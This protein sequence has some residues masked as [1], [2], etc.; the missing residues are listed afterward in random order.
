MLAALACVGVLACASGFGATSATELPTANVLSTISLTDPVAKSADPPVCT[1]AVA[2]LDTDNCG[3][4]SFVPGASKVL[5]LGSL[6]GTDVQAGSLRWTVSTSSPTG[7]VVRMSNTG[8]AP[9]LRSASSSIPDMQSS[10]LVPSASV[11]DATGFGVAMGDSAAD[12]EAAVDFTG[13]PWVAAGQQGELYSG[14]PAAGMEVAKRTTPQ[15]NDPFTATFA[16]AATA[17]Q[18]PTPG[19]YAGTVRIV[20]SII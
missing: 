7:Y 6:S 13:S 14:I 4:V 19:S 10:P 8:A 1:D 18:Q 15:S 17:G 20:A 12:N 5:R 3:D 9:V 11:D 16:V 2:P